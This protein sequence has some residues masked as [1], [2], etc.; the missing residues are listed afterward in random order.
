LKL[1]GLQKSLTITA[2]NHPGTSIFGWRR[3]C[4]QQNWETK[5]HAEKGSHTPGG[6]G[7]LSFVK[8][9]S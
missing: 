9:V 1:D 2:I 8:T 4:R 7:W 6:K 5:S 3:V